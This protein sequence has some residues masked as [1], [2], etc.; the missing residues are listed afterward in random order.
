MELY[1]NFVSEE[2]QIN[3]K[4]RIQYIVDHNYYDEGISEDDWEYF[5]NILK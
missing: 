4:F 2:R 1:H 3:F 5:K